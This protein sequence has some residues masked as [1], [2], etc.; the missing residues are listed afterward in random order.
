MAEG[1]FEILLRKALGRWH[2][3][4]ELDHYRTSILRRGAGEPLTEAI[5]KI[6]VNGHIEHRVAEGDGPVNALDEALR[7]G[8][9]PHYPALSEMRLVDYKVRVI[10]P[11]EGTAAKVCVVIQSRDKEHQWGT[12]GVSENIIEA[13]WLALVDSIEYKLLL[14]ED[15]AAAKHKP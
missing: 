10:N 5:V 13:S 1:S 6:L 15:K 12:V 7:R 4:F 9:K 3:F 2:R 11:T 8:L 14:E